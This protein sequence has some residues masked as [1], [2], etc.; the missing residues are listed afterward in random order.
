MPLNSSQK[1]LFSL[2]ILVPMIFVIILFIAG[3]SAGVITFKPAEKSIKGEVTATVELDFGDGSSFSKTI[4]LVNATVYD[5][6]NNLKEVELKSTYWEQF[7]SYI[8]DSIEYQGK[9]YES[10]TSHYWSFY[11]N[12]Q[13]AMEGA[14]KI[15]VNNNDLIEWKYESF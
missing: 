5:F 14:N 2:K 7:D 11:V 12:G 13:M 9:K 3:I 1:T 10:D 15:Y 8:I 6:I 4:T